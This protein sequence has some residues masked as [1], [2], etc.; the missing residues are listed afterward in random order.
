MDSRGLIAAVFW[1]IAATFF[2]AGDGGAR[3][4]DEPARAALPGVSG[5]RE[6]WTLLGVDESHFEHLR[7]GVPWQES[8]DEI[9]LRMMYRMREFRPQEVEAWA[10]DG[11]PDRLAEESRPDELDALRGE[12]F[13]L[14]GRVVLVEAIRLPA[15]LA[16]RYEMEEYYRAELRLED[17]R[18]AVAFARLVPHAWRRSEPMEERAGA[19]GFFLKLAGDG[20]SE[21]VFAAERIAWYPDTLLGNLGMDVGLLDDLQPPGEQ[22]ARTLGQMRLTLRNREAFY[23]MMAAVGRAEP[24]ALMRQ[25]KAELR[26]SG[27]ERY[28]VVP[29][30][31]SPDTQHG[32]LVMLS[33]TAREVVPVYVPDEDVR[34]RFGI[35]CYYQVSLFSEDSQGN[36]LVFCVREIPEG[37][38]TGKGPQFGQYV[39][40]AGFFFNTWAYRS[41]APAESESGAP[42]QL[43]PLLI[44]RTV[45]WH[46]Q[47][48]PARNPVTAAVAAG[49]FVLVL[50]GVW[51]ALWRYSRGDREFRRK[52]LAKHLSNGPDFSR[53]EQAGEDR[54]P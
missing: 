17:G 18:T 15:E 47:Q 13:R 29:L 44:G 35:D 5:P 25:A 16:Q 27:D 6:L 33:G 36:P 50:L 21:P 28:S 14:R 53:I 52:T 7:D 19:L 41:Q 1:S 9:L 22:P 42:W 3:A 39:T 31:N 38:P 20:Q 8:E 24:D 54:S 48:P 23:Q 45:V 4:A 32:Q 30:F 51:L 46:P 49:A 43:A 10:R 26:R 37:M 34:A 11:F 12:V 40:A 2:G